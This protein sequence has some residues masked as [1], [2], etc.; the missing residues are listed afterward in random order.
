MNPAY[1]PFSYQR[2]SVWPHDNSII[3]AGFARYG[4]HDQA[5]SVA[6]D[7]SEAGESFQGHR[8]PELYAGIERRPGSFPV[9]YPGANVPQAWAA[10]SVFLFLQCI[11]GLRADAPRAR[12]YVD[13]HL[14]SWLPDIALD[15]ITVGSAT[16]GIR[17]W[18]QG[19]DSC[20]EIL[21]QDGDVTV[22]QSAWLPWQT[23]A[24][25]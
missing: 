2:G 18:R 5:A 3:A 22:E 25:G 16:L 8:L 21:R 12:L 9:L 23:G 24:A 7:I 20:W 19:D 10:G 1:N 4:F 14:P 17:F 11:L 15:G 6:R 13:P